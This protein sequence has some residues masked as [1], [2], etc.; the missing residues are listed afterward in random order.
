MIA[1][2]RPSLARAIVVAP[3]RRWDPSKALASRLLAETASAPW[4][5]PVSLNHLAAAAAGGQVPRDRPAA[6]SRAQLAPALLRAA[7]A[8]DHKVSLLQGIKGQPDPALAAAVAGAESSAWRGGRAATA[9]G[10]ALL[11]RITQTV[12]GQLARVSI[13]PGLRDTLGAARGTV[14]VSISNQLPY[15]VRVRLAVQVPAGDSFTITNQPGVISIRA[16]QIVTVKLKVHAPLGTTVLSLRL[17]TAHGRPL[18]G[19]S[20]TLTVE[21]TQFGTVAIV[22]VAAALGVF[23]ISSTARAIRRG[24][25]QQ[26]PPPGPQPGPGP[27]GEAAGTGPGGQ[28]GA[29]GRTAG[30]P[31]PPGP[32]AGADT[33]NGSEAG[34][35]T[36]PRAPGEQ[37]GTEDADD[38]APAPGWPDR[39]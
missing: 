28:D 29:A 32:A 39:S 38:Y 15:Q 4:L 9:H 26:A 7:R 22:I 8:L 16:G 6:T 34:A 12:T 37:A 21:A 30:P 1:A 2:E 13:I 5:R 3:P 35:R 19:P 23:M 27:G 18:P 17:L 11:G 33:V 25:A 14:P 20:R 10:L 31:G 24:R 36:G